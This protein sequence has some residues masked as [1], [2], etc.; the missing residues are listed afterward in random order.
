MRSGPA[1]ILAA[2]ALWGSS[3][4]VAHFGPAGASPLSVGA[5]RIVVGG[6]L[7]LAIALCGAGTAGA[8]ARWSAWHSPS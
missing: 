7:L 8:C 3:G 6:G 1:A 5:A 2:A 4:T